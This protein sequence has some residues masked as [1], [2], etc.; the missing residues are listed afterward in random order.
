MKTKEQLVKYLLKHYVNKNGDIDI[1]RL[2]FGDFAG[3]IYQGHYTCKGSIHQSCH[4]CQS[5]ILQIGHTTPGIVFETG[6][7]RPVADLT[8][9]KKIYELINPKD[10]NEYYIVRALYKCN[11]EVEVYGTLDNDG[12]PYG[13]DSHKLTLKEIDHIYTHKH[14]DTLSKKYPGIYAL[15]AFKVNKKITSQLSTITL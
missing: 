8:K 6:H 5:D 4:T 3:D 15:E 14:L 1:S 11:G 7:K 10:K 9:D 12:L 2:D 13:S